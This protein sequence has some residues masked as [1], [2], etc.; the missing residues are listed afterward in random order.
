MNRV[1]LK[2]TMDQSIYGLGERFFRQART[3]ETGS[4]FPKAQKKEI[5]LLGFF[6]AILMPVKEW[7]YANGFG[8]KSE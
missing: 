2:E 4:V 8:G 1:F 7:R 6:S 5:F 3:K